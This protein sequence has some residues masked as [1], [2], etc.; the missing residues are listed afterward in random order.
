[1]KRV[2]CRWYACAVAGAEASGRR[3]RSSRNV[4]RYA[5]ALKHATREELDPVLAALKAKREAELRTLARTRTDAGASS[6]PMRRRMTYAIAR[7]RRRRRFVIALPRLTI[8]P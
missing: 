5:G 8:R 6:V 1:M 7:R 4:R 3:V 2:V